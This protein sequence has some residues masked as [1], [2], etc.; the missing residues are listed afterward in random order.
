[1][2]EFL[3]VT[4][5]VKLICPNRG[6]QWLATGRLLLASFLLHGLVLI[7]LALIGDGGTRGKG[8][9]GSEGGD[10]FVVTWIPGIGR[11]NGSR[12]DTVV[13]GAE[14]GD[15]VEIEK[16][17]EPKALTKK[18]RLVD[19]V[20]ADLEEVFRSETDDSLMAETAVSETARS[21]ESTRTSAAVSNSAFQQTSATK[22]REEISPQATV[23]FAHSGAMTDIDP[24]GEGHRGSNRDEGD[25]HGPVGERGRGTASG[26]GG[27]RIDFFGIVSRSKRVVY[28]IDASESMRRHNAMEIARRELWDSLQELPP[29]AQFQL[30]FFNLTNHTMNQ[31]G[32]RPKLLTATSSNLRKAKQFSA[33]IQPDSGT[34][35]LAAMTC[36]LSLEPD[37]I[38]LLTDA[39]DPELSS[40]DLWEIRR[41]N[42]R[43]A[44]IHVVEFGLGADL[45]R[46]SFLKKLTVQNYGTH[47]YRDLTKNER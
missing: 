46:D 44:L 17:V 28:V 13:S 11:G 41:R 33:G 9:A 2:N 45:S 15:S 22:S 4:T 10:A 3:A 19:V 14:G 32:T 16:P 34:D 30:V 26:T 35:R 42:Q 27:D 1:M 29:T 36:A 8:V 39:D 20:P 40:K 12:I 18:S 24:Q 6:K 23:S 38:Y 43:K 31:P 5:S 47:F 7:G 25:G 37:V 21:Q